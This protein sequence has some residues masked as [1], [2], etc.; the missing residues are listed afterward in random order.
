MHQDGCEDVQVRKR[1]WW[2]DLLGAPSDAL[3]YT[4]EVVKIMCAPSGVWWWVP[5]CPNF[6]NHLV[7]WGWRQTHCQHYWFLQTQW[8]EYGHLSVTGIHL[9]V[10]WREALSAIKVLHS[11]QR[12][13][14]SILAFQHAKYLD[15]SRWLNFCTPFFTTAMSSKHTHM[16][17][18]PMQYML[19]SVCTNVAGL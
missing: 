6:P 18:P 2:S 10:L 8:E 17:I 19:L 14:V 3:A 12:H 15:N 9:I 11:Q 13:D 7:V 4:I 16:P 5:L 1:R